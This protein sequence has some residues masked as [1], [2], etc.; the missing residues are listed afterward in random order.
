L[1]E[2]RICFGETDVN[3]NYMCKKFLVLFLNVHA[4]WA[5]NPLSRKYNKRAMGMLNLW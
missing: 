1:N 5:G 2:C 4:A 3:T